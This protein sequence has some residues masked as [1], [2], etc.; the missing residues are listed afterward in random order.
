MENPSFLQKL[1]KSSQNKDSMSFENTE[2]NLETIKYFVNKNI[3]LFNFEIVDESI[4]VKK[5]N[6]G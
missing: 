2:E 3:E 1:Q 4:I 6:N 5:I